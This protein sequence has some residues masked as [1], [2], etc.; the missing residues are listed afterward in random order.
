M[1]ASSFALLCLLLRSGLR[2]GVG[3]VLTSEQVSSEAITRDGTNQPLRTNHDFT[4][5]TLENLSSVSKLFAWPVHGMTG[6]GKSTFQNMRIYIHGDNVGLKNHELEIFKTCSSLESCSTG[7]DMIVLRPHGANDVAEILLD[8]EGSNGGKLTFSPL[9]FVAGCSSS[10][11]LVLLDNE[12]N[13]RTVEQAVHLA[14]HFTDAEILAKSNCTQRKVLVV[15]VHRNDRA[16][17]QERS[18]PARL[19]QLWESLLEKNPAES[20][21]RYFC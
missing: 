16:F 5:S 17:A 10:G 4:P 12:L 3:V 20:M 11:P 18:D 21:V 19:L 7:T 9:D 6:A 15:I 13:L 2:S 1:R 8:V 14:L